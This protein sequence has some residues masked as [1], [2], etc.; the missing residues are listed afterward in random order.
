[1][2]PTPLI[3]IGTSPPCRGKGKKPKKAFLNAQK[4]RAST[5][6]SK[7][8]FFGY[9]KPV[10]DFCLS[11]GRPFCPLGSF[12]AL[13]LLA[14]AHDKIPGFFPCAFKVLVRITSKKIRQLYPPR[15]AS[16]HQSSSKLL[17]RCCAP[18]SLLS[19]ART[20]NTNEYNRDEKQ[21]FV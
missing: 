14:R 10:F 15:L 9:R 12:F 19:G 8:R 1:M 3:L 20:Y 2:V 13:F 4:K 6:T 5:H 11:V 17:A 16:Q 21:G 18:C 7:S